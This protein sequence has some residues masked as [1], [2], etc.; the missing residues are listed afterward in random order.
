MKS[1]LIFFGLALLPKILPAQVNVTITTNNIT[2]FGAANGQATANPSGGTPP[3]TF[4][5]NNSST[6]QTV[7]N[8]SPGTYSVIVK[9]ANQNSQTASTAISQPSQLGVTAFSQSQICDVAPDGLA[10]SVAFGGTPPYSYAWSNGGT[11]PQ[12]D[13]L[14]G[15]IYT[16]TLTD[17]KG[18]TVINSCEVT[19]WDE[20]LWLM[21]TVTN[22]FCGYE[23]GNVYVSPMTG[24]G[25]YQY[26]W[27]TGETTNSIDNLAAGSYTV[28]VNDANGCAASI[29]E[30]LVSAS[31]PLVDILYDTT[32]CL[33]NAT[34]LVS[35]GLPPVPYY[36]EFL[37]TLNDPLDQIIAGQG[38]DTVQIQWLSTGA[39]SVKM[40]FG[41]NGFY[42]GTVN[43]HLEVAV[44]ADAS[45]PWLESVEIW[46]NP[47]SSF[48]KIDF[49][50]GMPK[51]ASL[52][53]SDIMGKIVLEK[54]IK[55]ASTQLQTS[56][57]PSGIYFI[58]IH[59]P[60]DE[61]AWR[62]IKK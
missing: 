16:V 59:T 52:V 30:F 61:K 37:W 56:Q 28:T 51:D 44:C 36:P 9:D 42:C 8:L 26:L 11:T 47:F 32:L 21:L 34:T 53:L 41:A 35:Y 49:P 12:I 23:D 46:P 1:T 22:P 58:K 40:Q 38:T 45:E 19:F 3:Y 17:A 39:K 6:T 14:T 24:T 50:S 5:W 55:E 15:G 7:S 29:D 4:V 27:S 33:G 60:A 57:I 48:L 31:Q 20:G 13:Q 62:L 18:C 43:H 25:P 54:S 10:T 2:C